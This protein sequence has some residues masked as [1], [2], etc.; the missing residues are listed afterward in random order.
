MAAHPQKTTI[1][2]A[3]LAKEDRLDCRLHIVVDAARAGALEEGESA[4]MRIEHHLLGLTRIG[5]HE[6]HPTV[7]QPDMRNLDSH[8]HPVARHATS[9][10]SAELRRSC[11]HSRARAAPRRSGSALAARAPACLDSPAAV[12]QADR[13]TH[14]F[15]G[16][17]AARARSETPSPPTGS[18][19]ARPSATPETPGRSP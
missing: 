14:R 11:P 1:E 3:I 7:A 4:I 6:R 13:A 12:H 17:A 16:M 9:W 15:G 2:L 8:C 5:P 19:C 18:P 10:R